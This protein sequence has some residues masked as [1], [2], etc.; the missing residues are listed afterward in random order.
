MKKLKYQTPILVLSS[1]S[2]LSIGL[3]SWIV[4][5]TK[6]SQKYNVSTSSGGVCYIDND[7]ST[8]YTTIEKALEI[9]GNL[10]G[11]RTVYVLPETN[12][13][14]S[15]QC[16]VASNTTLTFPYEGTTYER[17]SSDKEDFIS[18]FAT[19]NSETYCKNSVT[20][21]KVID[22]SGNVIPTMI[23]NGRVN[24]G[25]QRR[26]TGPQGCT[27]G[28]Y[29]EWLVNDGAV[30][31]VYGTLYVQGYIRE[32][33]D[34]NGSY[35]NVYSSGTLSQPMVSY[36][37][38]SAGNANAAIKENIFPFNY[39][40]C[41]QVSPGIYFYAGGKLE[42][43]VWMYGN[44]A[45]D[46]KA[47][48]YVI[49]SSSDTALVQST[50]SEGFIYWK[51]TDTSSGIT[52]TNSKFSHLIHL[53]VSGNYSL[54]YLAM[55][56]SVSITNVNIDSR[57]YYLPFS[58]FFNIE[59]LDGATFDIMY[60][61]KF[62]PGSKVN[63]NNGGT[64]NINNNTIIYNSITGSNG[65]IYSY[66]GTS[67]AILTNNGTININ[68][69]FGGKINASAKGDTNTNINVTST[70]SVTSVDAASY[71]SSLGGLINNITTTSFSLSGIAD[72]AVDEG[73]QIVKDSPLSNNTKYIHTTDGTNYGWYG[74]ELAELTSVAINPSSGSS[75]ANTSKTYTLTANVYPEGIDEST[76][77]YSWKWE[78]SGGNEA[79]L[80]STT[81]KTVSFTTPANSSTD[82]DINYRVTV[83]VTQTLEDGS[84]KTVSNSGD[85]TAKKDS[86]GCFSEK[87]N[88]LTDKGII[89]IKNITKD[90]ML[91]SYNHYTGKFEFKPISAVIFHGITNY[92]VMILKFNDGNSLEFIDSHG[93]FDV[94]LNKYVDFTLD[95]YQDY[96]GHHFLRVEN[97]TFKKVKLV[98]AYIEEKQTGSY[99]ILSSE[100]LNCV[101]NNMLNITSVLHGIYNIFNYDKNYKYCEDEVIRDIEKYGLFTYDDFKDVINEKIFIDYGFKWFKI[102]IGKGLF[103]MDT[104]QYYIEWLGS[105]IEN[106]EAVIY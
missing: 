62:L 23:I 4:T 67:A 50:S 17:S 93:L 25:G 84:I 72:I 105:C 21:N 3:S 54:S 5:E 106:G 29:V 38:G 39:F 82:N 13:I 65:N 24:I 57:N 22:S 46:M 20:I 70:Q 6:S 94:E 69:G 56:L 64:V 90:Y 104:L 36:D 47:S 18:G 37:W 96:I 87:T 48:A 66:S 7:T 10:S 31:D 2:L 78:S 11:N 44:T 12:P 40:D 95:S 59:I 35:I 34:N 52:L 102:S 73:G 16:T 81:G 89:N 58:N 80:S 75:E 14:I 83:V 55:D 43:S 86:G 68:S 100:N 9:A 91:L 61:V 79:T 76:L 26:S 85:Y 98:N 63:V 51:N 28:N 74:N 45:G 103:T 41:P 27:S 30:I 99:T 1:L 101:A 88:V 71:S 8:L 53:D 15:K 92:K 19:N 49:G 42:A 97:N 33:S 77:Y 60:P 32:T